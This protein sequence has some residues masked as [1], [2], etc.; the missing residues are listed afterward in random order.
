[1]QPE[2]Q[3]QT[4]KQR[5]HAQN[6]STTPA[7]ACACS[8]ACA[9]LQEEVV[10]ELVPVD[11]AAAVGIDLQ[12]ELQGGSGGDGWS[13]RPGAQ[14][15]WGRQAPRQ[16]CQAA[17]TPAAARPLPHLRNLL[18]AQARAQVRAQLLAEFIGVQLARAVRVRLLRS[19][20]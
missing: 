10:G 16:C 9:R 11:R 5:E 17:A 18:A 15:L 6:S 8:R 1:M 4:S 12:E 14:N 20:Q 2:Q 13:C 19:W 7:C 3:L